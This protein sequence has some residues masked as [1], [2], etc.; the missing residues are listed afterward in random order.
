MDRMDD[1]L[2]QIYRRHT[3]S[4]DFTE[5]VMA[6]VRAE[7]RRKFIPFRW[8]AVGALAASLTV[9]FFV[10]RQQQ[11]QHRLQQEAELAETQL[12]ESLQVAGFKIGQAREAILRPSQ[13][14]VQP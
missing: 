14:E 2:R 7:A 4:P 10:G 11:K 13:E 8:A 9:A 12:L 1:E 3:P 5:R 6:Q